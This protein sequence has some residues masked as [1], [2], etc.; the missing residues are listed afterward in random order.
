MQMRYI[1]TNYTKHISSK[2]FYTHELQED[3]EISILQIKLYDNLANLFTKSL[4]LATFDK[5][6]KGI[7]MRR[8][9]RFTRFKRRF[10]L[11][12]N[13]VFSNKCRENILLILHGSNFN[14]QFNCSRGSVTNSIKYISLNYKFKWI[15]SGQL[16]R[17][18]RVQHQQHIHSIKIKQTDFIRNR[19]E[20]SDQAHTRNRSDQ[21]TRQESPRVAPFRCMA[22]IQCCHCHLK[23]CHHIYK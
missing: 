3:G 23:G 14:D 18:N 15:Q 9:K 12:K 11:N 21:E 22:L 7:S 10:Y 2:L 5:C 1:K 8:L 19:L 13:P 6:V 17:F 16:I 4:P 20:W